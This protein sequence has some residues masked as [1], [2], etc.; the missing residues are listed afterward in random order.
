M[1]SPLP[2]SPSPT[3]SARTTNRTRKTCPTPLPVYRERLIAARAG[4][5]ITGSRQDQDC[6]ACF[7]RSHREVLPPPHSRLPVSLAAGGTDG[8]ERTSRCARGAGHGAVRET[9]IVVGLGWTSGGKA[10]FCAWVR[11]PGA[12]WPLSSHLAPLPSRP[13]VRTT[14]LRADAPLHPD[15]PHADRHFLGLLLTH[16]TNKRLLDEVAQVPS[17]RLRNKISGCELRPGL[18]C[19]MRR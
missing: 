13:P 18:L 17:K 2:P 7:S 14:A 11:T 15:A 10:R 6:E 8:M 1:P 19:R 9:G 5:S 16:S 3:L 12:D 4:I